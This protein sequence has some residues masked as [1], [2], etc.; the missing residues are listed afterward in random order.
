MVRAGKDEAQI[1]VI[2][3]RRARSICLLT[4]AVAGRRYR[5]KCNGGR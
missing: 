1:A 3:Q 5:Q 4:R 2:E